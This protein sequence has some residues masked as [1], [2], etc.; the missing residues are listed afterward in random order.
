MVTFEVVKFSLT[1][2]IAGLFASV[3]KNPGG[4][5]GNWLAEEKMFHL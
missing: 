4:G 2:L 3:L 1:V 5:G